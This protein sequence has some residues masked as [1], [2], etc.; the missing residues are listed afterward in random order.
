MPRHIFFRKKL[1][2]IER[3]KAHHILIRKRDCNNSIE[4][5]V[6]QP[7]IGLVQVKIATLFTAGA[8]AK[9]ISYVLCEKTNPTQKS[10]SKSDD[11]H[12]VLKARICTHLQPTNLLQKG[13]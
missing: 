9:Q 3:V 6:I 4:A 7:K 11:A 8:L 2:W 13:C 1:F 10:A 12:I 5:F